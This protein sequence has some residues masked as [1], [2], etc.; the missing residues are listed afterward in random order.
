MA[1]IVIADVDCYDPALPGV[2][3][4]RFATQGYVT[5]AQRTNLALQSE[6]L[7]TSPWGTATAATATLAAEYYGTSPFW[8]LAK[9]TTSG[10]E[11]RNQPIGAVSSGDVHTLTV[12]LL[13]GSTNVVSV[14]IYNSSNTWG[15]TSDRTAAIISGPGS[16]S[17]YNGALMSVSGL[18]AT[19]PTLLRISRQFTVA[20]TAIIYFYPGTPSSITIGD[21]IKAT[22]VQ[23]QAGWGYSTYIKTTT[24]AVS[25]PANASDANLYYDGRI[26]QPANIKRVC[27]GGGTTFG[28]TQIGYGDM[29]LVNNDGGLDGLLNYSFAGRAISIKLG[30][31]AANSGGVPTWVT[32]MSGT[33]EQAQLSWQKVTIRVRDR[34]QDLAKPLQQT[35]YG[36]TNVLPNGLDGVAADLQGRPKPLVFGQ[37]FNV[38]LPCVNTTRLIYQIHHGSA[39]QSVDGV[40]DRGAPLT[41]GTAYTSQSDMETNAPTAGQYRVWNSAAGTYVRLGGNPTG[42]VTADATQGAAA[43]NRTAAQLFNAVLTYAGISA[44]QIS[45]ADITA[46]DALVAYPLGVFVPADRDV[47][48]LEVLDQVVQSVGA[49]YGCDA[50]G[51]FRIARIDVPTGTSVGTLTATDIMKIERVASTDAGVGVPAWKVKLGYQRIYSVQNDLTASVT[52]ARKE[53]LAQEYRRVE[54]SDSAVLT[55]NL[56]SPEI[57]F[58]TNLVSATDAAAEASRRLT[59]Y[60]TRRDVYQVTVRVS[61]DLAAVLDLGKI[62]TLQINRYGMSAGQKFLIVGLKTD[63]RGYLFELTLWG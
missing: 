34:Q 62:V 37:V 45:S 33:M 52:A 7:G 56:T 4:L 21:S 9:T 61:A 50:T 46:L 19:E 6:N 15:S 44:G 8:V 31:V 1:Q 5:D 20:G 51:V 47:T 49:W 43:A 29:V 14:G 16:L 63:M 3:T 53:Y 35:R 58:L 54:A 12:A 40:Y 26:Q 10:S 22:R 2:R 38:P 11:A 48:T 59:I 25:V 36:G 60:K 23:V 39:L 27:F 24:S 55:A 17:T 32:V 18:S 42:Q 13:A 30:T 41:A 28:R 57:E